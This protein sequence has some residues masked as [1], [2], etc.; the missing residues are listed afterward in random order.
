MVNKN[1]VNYLIR[2]G[3][4]SRQIAERLGVSKKTVLKWGRTCNLAVP[5]GKKGTPAI[6]NKSIVKTLLKRGFSNKDIEQVFKAKPYTLHSFRKRNNLQYSKGIPYKLVKR[7]SSD[8]RAVL[9]GTL[10]GDSSLDKYGR[11]SCTH[12]LQQEEYLL[13]K[14][15]LLCGKVG[16]RQSRYDSRTGKTYHCRAFTV[17]ADNS[18]RQLRKSLYQPTKQI[19]KEVLRY[20]NAESLAYLFM[21]DGYKTE[22]SYRIATNSFTKESLHI[23]NNHCFTTLGIS[24]TVHNEN[25][26][27]LPKKYRVIFEKLIT[28]FIHSTMMYKMH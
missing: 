1:V 11:L 20:F 6:F 27:Y 25:R 13:H 23:F 7:E 21:D 16:K 2:K 10:L 8:Y 5:H 18:K 9:I 26:L 24:F 15:E 3:Y 12:S 14:A 19:T 22:G 17:K 4:T 28:P